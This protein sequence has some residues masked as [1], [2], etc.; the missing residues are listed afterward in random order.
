VRSQLVAV[1]SAQAQTFTVIHN[2]TSGADGAIPYSG[3]DPRPRGEPLWHCKRVQ[4]SL[5]V[6]PRGFE[7]G[8]ESVIQLP[9]Q[10]RRFGAYPLWVLE[11]NCSLNCAAAGSRYFAA[12]CRPTIGP[13]GW[14]CWHCPVARF[15]AWYIAKQY[16]G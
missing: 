5:P 7:M 11:F 13:E 16:P 1:Q 15:H 12:N 3:P 6:V 10:W 2:F 4:D 9:W 8:V 14:S